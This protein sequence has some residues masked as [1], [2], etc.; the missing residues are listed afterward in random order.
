MSMSSSSIFP[1]TSRRGVLKGILAGA[2]AG[3]PIAMQAKA[4]TDEQQLDACIAQLKDILRRMYPKADEIRQAIYPMGDGYALFLRGLAPSVWVFD[5]PGEYEVSEWD[6]VSAGIY[7]IDQRYCEMD[8]RFYLFGHFIVDGEP[9]ASPPMII[10][11]RQ[12][13]RKLRAA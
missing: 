2:A 9:A 1:A 5:G 11:P 3:A 10:E 12:I 7:Y 6:D 8:R 13:V 4:P